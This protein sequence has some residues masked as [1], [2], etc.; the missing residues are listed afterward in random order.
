[1][2]LSNL[3]KDNIERLFQ[4][5]NLND[6]DRND[7]N[8]LLNIRSNYATYSKLELI[9]RQIEFL[10]TEALNIIKIHDLNND[11]NNIKCTFRKVPGNYYYVYLNNNDEKIL[12][13]I[14]PDE[15]NNYK[16]FI[17]KVYYDYDYQFYKV[18]L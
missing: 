16:Q 4:M 5:I 3:N 6:K 8:N 1:M 10:K 7:Y 14:G 2:A 12:S 9:A 13:L 11:L 17:T 15:W 18:D